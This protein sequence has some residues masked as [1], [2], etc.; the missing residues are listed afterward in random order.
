LRKEL[1]EEVSQVEVHATAG[2]AEG[3]ASAAPRAGRLGRPVGPELLGL[4]SSKP[5]FAASSPNSS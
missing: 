4:F 1:S 3:D 5:I 2:A